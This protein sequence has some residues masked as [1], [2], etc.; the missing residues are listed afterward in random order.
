MVQ[1][2]GLLLLF[3]SGQAIAPL[4]APDGTAPTTVAYT[5]TLPAS[6]ANFGTI[7]TGGRMSESQ[8]PNKA[9]NEKEDI[10]P[11]SFHKS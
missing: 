10:T 2:N 1:T 9:G 4:G 8:I 11:P 3:A 7:V 5:L 6:E